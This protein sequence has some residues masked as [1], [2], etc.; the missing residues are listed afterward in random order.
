[1]YE[2]IHHVTILKVVLTLLNLIVFIYLANVVNE[3]VRLRQQTPVAG[4]ELNDVPR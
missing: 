4:T 2:I 1:M 3:K